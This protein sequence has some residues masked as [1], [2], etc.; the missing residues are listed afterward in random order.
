ME[1]EIEQTNINSPFFDKKKFQHQL[2]IIKKASEIAQSKT[3]YVSAHDD[4]IVLAI[5]VVEDFLR[6]KHRLCYGGQAINAHLPAKY[7]FYDPEFSIPDYDF[8]TPQQIDDI[9]ILVKDLKKA[10]F[11]EISVREGMHEGTV[12]IYVDFVPV[13]DMTSIDPKLYKILAAREYRVDGISYLDANSLRML[14]YLELSRPRG[15]VS[16]WAKVFERLALF[17]EFVPSKPCKISR[18]AFYGTLTSEQTNFILNYI[19]DNK[20]IFA[21]ADLL[22]FYNYALKTHKRNPSWILTSKK[23]ILFFSS[24]IEN[25]AK[26]LQSEFNFLIKSEDRGKHENNIKPTP[27]TIKSFSSKG[28]DLIPTM[29]IINQGDKVLVLII[30]LT[31]CNSYFNIPINDGKIMRIASM[32]TLITLYFSLGLIDTK[33]FDMGS[34]E[35]L[36][37][38]LV[39]ISIKARNNPDKFIFPFISVKCAGKQTSLPSLIRAKVKRITQ[40]KQQLKELLTNSLKRKSIRNINKKINAG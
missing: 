12:K 2:D 20:R 33:Y 34:M 24:E 38:K 9:N 39:D 13:A 37:N 29:K 6:K 35:C 18:R 31:A 22:Q 16:R 7:K 15:E 11:Q 10:G 19:I 40:K 36:A 25:D 4:N 1:S 27:I 30:D 3:D 17:N 26:Q 28:I 5:S 23:P 21:G 8:F 32:D 14:M